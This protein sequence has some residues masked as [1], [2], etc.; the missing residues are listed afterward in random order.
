MD[1]EEAFQ[2]VGEFGPYQQRA[3]AVLVLTQ[4]YMACQ[5]MLIVLVGSTPEYHLE[6]QDGDSSGLQRVV[7]TEDIDSI[8]TE[9]FLVKQ[10]AYKVSL[11]GSLFFAGLLFG[12]V[13]FGPL[14]DKI[15]RRPVYLTG[16]EYLSVFA[17]TLLSVTSLAL[18]GKLMVSAAFNIAYVYT[19]ELY[20]TVI[21]NAG[22]GVCS[23]ACRVGGII[24]P[25][26]PS[27]RALH[28]SMPFTVFCLSGFSAGCLG[29]LLP[30]TLNRPAVD[31]LE[32]L[33]NDTHC[34]VLESK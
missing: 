16:G 34:R 17:G 3:V 12:N 14:S 33:S 2:V 15:G 21:R 7:F 25:F 23:M 30:E 6:P 22:L 11:A 10:Q 19:S 26:V 24:A 5:S 4:V 9:W 1:L 20:P 13:F 29:L 31:T 27:M 8:V 28:T 18:L 32:E